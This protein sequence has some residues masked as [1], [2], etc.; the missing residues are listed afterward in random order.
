M[1]KYEGVL[2]EG[3]RLEATSQF[4]IPQVTEERIARAKREG[5]EILLLRNLTA[6]IAIGLAVLLVLVLG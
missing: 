6:A 2:R 5:R 3:L 4:L 1:M